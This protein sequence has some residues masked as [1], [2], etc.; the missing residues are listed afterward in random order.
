MRLSITPLKHQLSI[1]F[2]A[3]G[4]N[5]L[6][7]Q[8]LFWGVLLGCLA[9]LLIKDSAYAPPDSFDSYTLQPLQRSMI[10][11][12][13]QIANKINSIG[14]KKNI[15]SQ[16]TLVNFDDNTQFELGI[17]RF[18]TLHSQKTLAQALEQIEKCNPLTIVLDLD[19]RGA[20][21]SDL[22][23]VFR[24][25]HNVV[26]ALFGHLDGSTDLPSAQYTS[27]AKYYGYDE[28]PI[29]DTGHQLIFNHEIM[30]LQ[31]PPITSNTLYSIPSLA[32][33]TLGL[34]ALRNKIGKRILPLPLLPLESKKTY[35]IYFSSTK[36]T[37]PSISLLDVISD[38]FNPAL[39]NDRI[40][41]ISSTLTPHD[42]KTSNN[43]SSSAS[44][45]LNADIIST[46]LNNE[47]IYS[48][49]SSLPLIFF[50]G[51]V[52]C[53]IGSVLNLGWRTYLLGL[54]ILLI[55]VLA[56]IAFQVYY[57][58]LPVLSPLAVLCLSFIFATFNNLD[59]GL[60][61]RNRE[62]AQARESMQVRAEEER[63]RI[64]EDLHDE[65]LPALS[66][67]ARMAESISKNY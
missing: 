66:N 29:D 59:T 8:R 2:D 7:Y 64:A 61:L 39:F 19:L 58:M 1:V 51:A 56:Q 30:L 54:S 48:L 47:E 16:T 49:K 65:T 22:V 13:Y 34:N 33:S 27:T 42:I 60:K 31:P 14:H 52:F 21:C 55:F 28:L 32:E 26:L 25:Y 43:F 41:I 36:F 20:V 23:N 67:V 4:K 24:Q 62:L 12:R 63:Q 53:G 9:A 45:K 10:N 11:W 18:N 35:P 37:Y 5:G 15:S 44:G 50:L 46:I 57:L 6:F 3:Q 38:N 17:A 40:V